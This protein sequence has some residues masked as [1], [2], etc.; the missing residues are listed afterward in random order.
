MIRSF[1]LAFTVAALPLAAAA[2]PMVGDVVG[3][4]PTEATAALAKAGCTVTDFEAEVGSIEA[5]CTD[6]AS[7][8]KSEVYIDP[9]TGAVTEIKSG[10]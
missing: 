8:A 5:K 1:L 6:A 4:N 10:D 2:A 9:K 3:T 7:G